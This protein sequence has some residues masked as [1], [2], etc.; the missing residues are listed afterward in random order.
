M[1]PWWWV[2]R[3]CLP[4][5]REHPGVG[6]PVR[7]PRQASD[8]PHQRAR[9]PC[10]TWSCIS[11]PAW[12]LACRLT[13][14]VWERAR[15]GLLRPN[16][17]RNPLSR[18][19]SWTGLLP[20]VPGGAE[21]EGLPWEGAGVGSPGSSAGLGEAGKGL[22]IPQAWPPQGPWSP[23]EAALPLLPLHPRPLEAHTSLPSPESPPLAGRLWSG[24]GPWQSQPCGPGSPWLLGTFIP[25][26]WVLSGSPCSL[27]PTTEVSV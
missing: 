20:T 18:P 12:G 13:P 7:D 9:G 5:L 1:G 14:A 25:C 19:Y 6:H 26:P 11:R 4:P 17:W 16:S 8:S 21:W 2:F 10:R 3:A 15:C 27:T 22:L 24:R 23:A